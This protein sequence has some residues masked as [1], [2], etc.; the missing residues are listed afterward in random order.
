LC[1]GGNDFLPKYQGISHEK[2]IS[3]VIDTPGTLTNLIKFTK[4]SGKPISGNLNEEIY[5]N[6]VKKLTVLAIFNLKENI[7]F[8]FEFSIF[9]PNRMKLKKDV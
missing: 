6:I 3:T 1:L 4:E 7:D 9:L 2:W 8:I 5:L